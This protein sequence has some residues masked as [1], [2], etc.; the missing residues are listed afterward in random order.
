ML[1]LQLSQSH[2]L[3]QSGGKAANLARLASSGYAIPTSWVLPRAML[4]LFLA[5][6]ELDAKI[7][8][9]LDHYETQSRPDQIRAYRQICAAV[10]LAPIPPELKETVD[11]VIAALLSNAPDG[12]AVRSSGVCEDLEKASFAG[13]YESFLGITTLAAFWQSVLGCWCSNWSPQAA[14]YARKMGLAL[15]PDGM[16]VLVQVM[17]PAESA[18]VIFTCDPASGDP[19]RFV[20]NATHGLSVRL[21]SGAAPGDRFELAW[22]TGEILARR[23]VRKP[24]VTRFQAGAL[25]ETILD[26]AEQLSSALSDDQIQAIAHLALAI[27]RAF[28]RRM[29]IE[30]A[31]AGGQLYLLQARPLTALPPFFP[32]QL[33]P[34]EAQETWTPYLNSYATL[35]PHERLIAPY[36][37]ERWMSELWQRFLTAEDVFPRGA[38]KE[39]DFNGY[40]YA[41]PRKWAGNP[42]DPARTERWLDENEPRLRRDWLAQLERARRANRAADEA[43]LAAASARDWVRIVL[44]LTREEDHMQAAV[45]YAAQ[46]MI[47]TCEDLLERFFKAVLPNPEIAGLPGVLLQGLSCYSVERTAAAQDLATRAREAI[48][49]AASESDVPPSVGVDLRVDPGRTH[50]CAP[51]TEIPEDAVRTAFAEKPLLEVVPFLERRCPESAFLGQFRR[52][53]RHYG[54]EIPRAGQGKSAPGLD[55]EGLLLVIKTGLLHPEGQRTVKDVLAASVQQRQAAAQQVRKDLLAQCPGQ[56]ERFDKLLDWAQFW[57]PALDNRKWHC[58][59]TLRLSELIARAGEAL[60]AEGLLEHREH[61]KLLTPAEWAAYAQTGDAA[62]LRSQYQASRRV[63]ERNRRLQPPAYLGYAPVTKDSENPPASKKQVPISIPAQAVFKGEPISGGQVRGIAYKVSN[64]ESAEYL[65]D[66]SA[67]QILI[68]ASDAFNA[69]WRR[70]WYSLFMVVGGLVTVRG[71]QLHHAT[72]IARECGLPF[73]NLPD[74]NFSDLPD[75]VEVELDGKKGVLCVVAAVS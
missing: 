28:D 20:L 64:L 4:G 40:R 61:F 7:R 13:I 68:C 62:V 23:V 11:P 8:A 66:L 18:G 75:R 52:F 22:D 55:I 63:Y 14:A 41:T 48:G 44:D 34:A 45:W 53:C 42:S 47:F 2:D 19:W 32:H 15:A 59:I 26:E 16:A 49:W 21:L 30:W 74:A 69:Q 39:R 5:H 65:D 58:A 6:N 43:A 10:E 31:I 70:D 67:G 27:D 17:I 60:V 35:N 71:S 29:D 36:H 12:L 54:L 3:T 73:I 72:Q 1:P 25:T 56:I 46:W 33:A 50:R 9:L 37:R 38:F 57:T 24:S 51:T